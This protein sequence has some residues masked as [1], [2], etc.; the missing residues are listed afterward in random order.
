VDLAVIS[1]SRYRGIN[2]QISALGWRTVEPDPPPA[3]QPAVV[4]ALVREAVAVAGGTT[5]ATMRDLFGDDIAGR[6]RD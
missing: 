6:E 4:P 3:E 5:P 1:E 2:A